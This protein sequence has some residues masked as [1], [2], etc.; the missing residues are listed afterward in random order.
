MKRGRRRGFT[1]IELLVV[2]AIIA[3]LIAILLPSLSKAKEATKRVV[4]G[5]NLKGQG[6]AMSIYASGWAN[7]LP[8]FSTAGIQWYRDQSYTTTP[9][10]GVSFGEQLTATQLGPNTPP[11]SVRRWFYCPSNAY[12]NQSGTWTVFPTPAEHMG[13]GYNYFNDRWTGSNTALTLPLTNSNV[14]GATAMSTPRADGSP[15]DIS[16]HKLMNSETYAS[17]KELATDEIFSTG[18]G[19][20]PDFVSPSHGGGTNNMGTT[21]TS[22]LRGTLPAG[23]N[24]LALDGSATWRSWKGVARA[25]SLST[26]GFPQCWIWVIDAR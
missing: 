20:T 22:H 10:G 18:A 1:L 14:S 16:Y 7:R 2:V 6:A 3:L 25:T 24:T 4:C 26:P 21:V 15:P 8:V 13:L 19:A 23:A 11:Q 5:S 12:D 17:D 9:G